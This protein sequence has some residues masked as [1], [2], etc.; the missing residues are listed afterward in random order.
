M[1]YIRKS[2]HD[3]SIVNNQ[4]GKRRM[5]NPSEVEKLLEE[6]PNLALF[7]PNSQSVTYF[8]NRIRSIPDLP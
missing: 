8:R 6:F 3:W 4:N 1:F 5:L 2:L 7:S